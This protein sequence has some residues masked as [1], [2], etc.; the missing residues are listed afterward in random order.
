MADLASTT[1]LPP[2][3][4][5]SIDRNELSRTVLRPNPDVQGTT[6]DGETVLLDLSSGR[7]YTLNRLGSVIWEHCAGQS[8]MA[9]I[10]AA[11]CDRFE[12]APERALD[13][14]VALV[15]ELIQEGLLQQERR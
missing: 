9:D 15:N 7:Y 8:T 12:V 13:D 10:H 5:S 6:M 11:I 14:L 3:T 4:G 2:T 1:I